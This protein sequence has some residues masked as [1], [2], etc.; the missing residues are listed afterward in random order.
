MPFELEDSFESGVVIKVVGVGGG[1]NNAVNRMIATNIRGVEFIVINTDKQALLQSSAEIKIPIGEKITKGHGAGAD[2]SV[3]QRAAEENVEEITNA[4]KGAD[5]VFITAGMGGGTGTGAAPVVAKI[6]KELGI[7][8]IGI[9]TKPFSFEGKRRMEAAERGIAEMRQNV[10]SL[11]IIPNERLKQISET[12]ITLA[13]AF[14]EA[15]DVLRRGAQAI[16]DLMNNPGFVNLDFADVTA[17]MQNAGCAH[18]GVGFATGKDKATE[19]AKMA[20]SSPLLETSIKG[21]RGIL[22]NVT[23]SPD[24]GLDECEIASSMVEEEAAADAMVIWGTTFDTSLEDSMSLTVIA[25]GFD[26]PDGTPS[27][28]VSK[29]STVINKGTSD[30]SNDKGDGNNGSENENDESKDDGFS[31]EEF[32][33]IINILKKSRPQH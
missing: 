25:T 12:R 15:D 28:P 30:T 33:D 19:A 1:G 27:Q 7:L 8:T 22:I 31:E 24:I 14:A 17:V 23:A 26:S 20:I 29:T 10:D 21:A 11:V 6:A 5:M 13:N 18:M 4:I 2:P 32:D 9:V 3:G 16:S